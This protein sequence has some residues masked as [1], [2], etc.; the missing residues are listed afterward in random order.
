MERLQEGS[1]I[2]VVPRNLLNQKSNY[3]EKGEIVPPTYV[4]L[5]LEGNKGLNFN[6]FIFNILNMRSIL[7][8]LPSEID[9]DEQLLASEV[10]LFL[11]R[12]RRSRY[13]LILQ[14]QP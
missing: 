14:R 2:Q 8:S 9:F 11:E 5:E 6:G 3:L 4:V 10:K 1:G 12:H 13:T 7:Y